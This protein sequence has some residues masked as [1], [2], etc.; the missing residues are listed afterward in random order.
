MT[1][2]IITIHCSASA[3]GKP[4]SVSAIRKMHLARGLKDIGY[5]FVIQS[6]GDINR[7][8]DLDTQGAHVF[9]ENENN[10][11]ICLIGTDKFSRKQFKV[12]SALIRTLSDEYGIKEDSIFCHY[13]FE[14]AK[15]QGKTCPNF[16]LEDFMELYLHDS[17]DKLNGV[18]ENV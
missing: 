14:S 12:L 11:G 6:S 2:K 16:K 3:N 10:V 1:P 7:G 4:L 8:R 18:L 17:F 5:H 13:Q 15:Q 9:K